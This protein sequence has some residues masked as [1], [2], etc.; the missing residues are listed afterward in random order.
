MFT[1]RGEDDKFA[2]AYVQKPQAGRHDWVYDLDI[3]SM[4]PSVIRS[5]NISP[6]TKVGKVEGWDAVEF[7]KGDTIKNYTLKNGHGKTIDTVDNKQLKSYLEETGLSISSNGIMYRTDKQGLIP[8]LL[9]KWFEERVEMRK[10]V[11]KFHEQG[12]KKKI[13]IL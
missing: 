3:T 2:G 1:R 6:E 8:A 9:T 7:L 12:D 4:Y 5:L 10:L 11:K 13:A